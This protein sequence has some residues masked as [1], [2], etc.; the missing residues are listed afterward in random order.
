MSE[1]EWPSGGGAGDGEAAG[2]G[3]GGALK[4]VGNIRVNEPVKLEVFE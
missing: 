2:A 4:S 3:G 1:W